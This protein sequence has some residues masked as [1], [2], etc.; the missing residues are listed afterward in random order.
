M[1][2]GIPNKIK[3]TIKAFIEQ[4]IYLIIAGEPKE[5]FAI[6]E[7]YINQLDLSK[8]ILTDIRY[9]PMELVRI[10]FSASDIVALPY[11]Y[12]FQSGLLYL[13]FAYKRPVIVTDVGGI[14]EIVEQGKNGFIVP[15]RD[16]QSLAKTIINSF[17]DISRLEQMGENAYIKS[18]RDFSWQSIAQSTNDI[19]KQLIKIKIEDIK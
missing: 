5:D 13:A 3:V 17:S 7:R 11:T 9:I 6:Y 1:K 19:Y 16:S 2:K 18:K 4:D 14:P 10:Y 15:P 8:F 12:I